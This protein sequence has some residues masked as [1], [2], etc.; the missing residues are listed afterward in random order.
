MAFAPAHTTATGMVAS[1]VRSAETSPSSPR[2]TPPIPPVA[3]TGI[4]E[5]WA[6]NMVAATVVA[7]VVR[8]ART[9]P[10]S[11][12]LTLATPSADARR[13]SWPVDSPT[14]IDPSRTA[15]VAG[16]APAS[17]TAASALVAVSRLRG[18]GRPW[19]TSVD[20]NATTGRPSSSASATSSATCRGPVPP[21]FPATV[22]DPILPILHVYRTG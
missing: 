18:R 5:R 1:A 7:P 21:T 12:R 15:T 9:W 13:S 8:P 20:S 14:L 4:P 22:T 16:T 2:C 17:R 10:R 11:R 6:A 3:N 19:D